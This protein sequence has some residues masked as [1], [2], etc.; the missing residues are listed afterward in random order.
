[1]LKEKT[2]EYIQINLTSVPPIQI[3]WEAFK[4]TCRGWIISYATAK[5][6][7]MGMKK[8]S[9]ILKTKTLESQHLRDPKNIRFKNEMMICKAELQSIIHEETAFAMFRLHRKYFESGDKVGKMLALRLKQL[10]NLH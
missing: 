4:A 6:K 7:G 1:M 10:Q 2:T 3:V 8:N 5:K 9:F